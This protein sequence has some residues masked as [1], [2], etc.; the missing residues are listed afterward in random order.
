MAQ[1]AQTNSSTPTETAVN[2]ATTSTSVLALDAT[3]KF[4]MLVNDSDTTIYLSFSGTAVASTGTRL[5]ANGGTLLFDRYVPT[6]AI[7]GI[8]GG[9][10]TKVLL[11]TVG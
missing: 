10:G 1:R 8:Q 7:T 3:R 9:S 4:L 2:V 6:G 11:V 5:N